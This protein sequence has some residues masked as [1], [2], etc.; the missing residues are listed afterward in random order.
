M[1]A[2]G[3]SRS[4]TGGRYCLVS[5]LGVT[6]GRYGFL[7]FQNCI[8]YRAM[9][10]LGLT[11]SSTGCGNCLVSHF[12]VT[13]SGYSFLC[14]QNRITYGAMLAFGF[15]RSSTGG[16]YCLVGD[17][18]VTLG[19]N[20]SLSNSYRTANGAVL[21]GCLTG[22]GTGGRYCRIG[23]FRVTLCRDNIHLHIATNLTFLCS[24]T[25]ICAGGLCGCQS[26]VTMTVEPFRIQKNLVSFGNLNGIPCV[27]I[28]GITNRLYRIAISESI[29]AYAFN[30]GRNGNANRITA[31][32][33]LLL[34]LQNRLGKN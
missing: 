31:L 20:G 34:N 4:S 32:E 10:A 14:F 28:S 6:L 29:R 24:F 9:L 5:D 22:S 12:R 26:F 15:T 1:L 2:F 21:T 11:G 33:C 16:R 13:L 17:L 18:R 27:I 23:H 8:T 30:A 25:L 3:F 7:C 19:G